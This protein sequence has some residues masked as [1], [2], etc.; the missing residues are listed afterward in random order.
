VLGEKLFI[1]GGKRE[2][3]KNM[4]NYEKLPGSKNYRGF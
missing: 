2:E 4:D 1:E 3:G